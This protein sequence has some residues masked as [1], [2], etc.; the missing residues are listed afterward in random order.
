[1]L[2]MIDAAETNKRVKRFMIS[3]C[4]SLKIDKES[5]NANMADKG[6]KHQND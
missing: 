6:E 1:M 3:E 2:K 5:R 4:V